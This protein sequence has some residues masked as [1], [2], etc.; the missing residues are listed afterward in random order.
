MTLSAVPTGLKQLVRALFPSLERLG[1]CHSVPLGQQD[2]LILLGALRPSKALHV[3]SWEELW[4][5]PLE[6]AKRS[7]CRGAACLKA[8][9][10]RM[11][12]SMAH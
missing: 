7:G 1:Y 5:V 4:R 8:G 12:L 2:L 10:A 11:G 9:C 6:F 3:A